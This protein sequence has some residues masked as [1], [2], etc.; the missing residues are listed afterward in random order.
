MNIND[1][2]GHITIVAGKTRLWRSITSTTV[3]YAC[4]FRTY[5]AFE[6]TIMQPQNDWG[7][8]RSIRERAGN[9]VFFSAIPSHG[10]HSE[11]LLQSNDDK[12]QSQSKIV[13]AAFYKDW[14]LFGRRAL[15]E[16]QK[17][18]NFPT[19]KLSEIT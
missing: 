15:F 9:A 18:E 19:D 13:V 6:D 10:A 8:S 17:Q 12:N 2:D 3:T 7:A 11:T 5:L 1:D 14:W 4:R 16:A